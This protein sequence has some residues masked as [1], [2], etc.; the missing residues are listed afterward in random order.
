MV[1][2]LVSGI[3]AVFV[4]TSATG[5]DAPLA[6]AVADRDA[7]AVPEGEPL[8]ATFTLTNLS[9]GPITLGAVEAGCACQTAGGLPGAL[10]AGASAELKVAMKTRG[11][12]GRRRGWWAVNYT[13]A[14]GKAGRVVL[15]VT[16][17]VTA[18]GK[19]E[20][21]PR[22]AQ[23][24]A[25]ELGEPVSAAVVL[26]EREP[27]GEPVAVTGVDGP[28]WLSVRVQRAAGGGPPRFRL[29]LAGTP[30]A[31]PGRVGGAVRVSTDHPRYG[32]V[33]VP[34]EAFVR[35]R[36]RVTPRSLV[37]IV[38][39]PGGQTA[40]RPATATVRGRNGAAVT[41]VRAALLDRDAAGDPAPLPAGAVVEVA[42]E[43][44]AW[45]VTVPAATADG[46]R[47]TRLT[48]R[49]EVETAA[50]PET[51]DL[52]LLVLRPPAVAGA[53]TAAGRTG[54]PIRR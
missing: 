11:R 38:G 44:G 27:G 32:A 25:A 48:L 4:G 47:A 6:A 52:P 45:R 12:V 28:D 20:P 21:T 37:Q 1:R 7:G 15:S 54:P 14:D 39:G 50:G 23:L 53:A 35:G 31:A 43:A 42:E 40:A 19:L 5:A 51:H 41:G 36:A 46:P 18:A 16:A 24:G 13:A 33:E 17:T 49:L 9:A 8:A 2:L 3:A 26:A 34:F 22:V 29:V 10:A 30:P